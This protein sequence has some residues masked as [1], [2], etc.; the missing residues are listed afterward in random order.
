MADALAKVKKHLGRDAV[1]LGT[2]TYTP[3]GR[4]GRAGEQVVEI[5]ATRDD[6]GAIARP[7]GR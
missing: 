3:R 4:L 7:V 1:I 2:R 5:T 6:A